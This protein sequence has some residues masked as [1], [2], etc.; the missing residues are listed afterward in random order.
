MKY[1]KTWQKIIPQQNNFRPDLSGLMNTLVSLPVAC[2]GN[3]NDQHRE[4]YKTA[5]PWRGLGNANVYHTFPDFRVKK[6]IFAKE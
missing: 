6:N 2:S 1:E 4:P 5:S 3:A